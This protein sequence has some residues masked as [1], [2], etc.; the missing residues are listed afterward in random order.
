MKEILYQRALND[1]TIMAKMT[2][3][4]RNGRGF[5]AT[6]AAAKRASR[7]VS[8][9]IP[10]GDGDEVIPSAP[11]RQPPALPATSL[12]T[13]QAR[14]CTLPYAEFDE[15]VVIDEKTPLLPNM[16]YGDAKERLERIDLERGSEGILELAKSQ[17][18]VTRRFRIKIILGNACL[19]FAAIVGAACAGTIAAIITAIFATIP[20]E[21]DALVI[22]LFGAMAGTQLTLLVLLF[23]ALGLPFRQ[24]LSESCACM[25]TALI[26]ALLLIQA[27][28]W[29]AVML[30]GIDSPA[31]GSWCDAIGDAMLLAYG[32]T[33][34]DGQV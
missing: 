26:Y 20:S 19:F 31:F 30:G 1:N 23:W 21:C 12:D 29:I 33:R 22:L 17:Q 9:T 16:P 32:V 5:R 34:L 8:A 4:G 15:E 10:D 18:R 14:F 3:L 6:L 7:T 2:L 25:W 11:A 13:A 28:F 24:A 27:L